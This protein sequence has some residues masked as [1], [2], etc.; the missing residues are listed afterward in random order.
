MLERISLAVAAALVLSPILA[1]GGREVTDGPP[2]PGAP[3]I[4]L[5]PAACEGALETIAELD[6][7]ALGGLAAAPDGTLFYSIAKPTDA[8]GIYTVRAGGAPSRISTEIAILQ[9]FVDGP[10]LFLVGPHGI[11]KLPIS[12][13]ESTPI[14]TPAPSTFVRAARLDATSAFYVTQPLIT[15][16]SLGVPFTVNRVLLQ[17]GEPSVVFASDEGKLRP[18]SLVLNGDE[19]LIGGNDSGIYHAPKS[20]GSPV[21][22]HENATMSLLV[23]SGGTIFSDR[24][25]SGLLISTS[26]PSAPPTSI[27]WPL[28]SALSSGGPALNVVADDAWAYIGFQIFQNG[29]ARTAIARLPRGHE[30]VNVGGCTVPGT[31]DLELDEGMA[32][33][34]SYV[35]IM[36]TDPIRPHSRIVRMVR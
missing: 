29:T 8:A 7:M 26:D 35:N 36:L 14:A 18:G 4:A 19:I 11:R 16:P 24:W 30:S 21:L 34:A 1:C 13:G 23:A 5:V 15:G 25:E 10:S 31:Q 6:G 28:G 20:G 22:L 9:I 33:D 12:G 17:G 2:S 32:L 27:G 3:E